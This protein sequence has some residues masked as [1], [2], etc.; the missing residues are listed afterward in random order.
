[1]QYTN[2][3]FVMAR[4]IT[5]ILSVVVGSISSATMVQ[6]DAVSGSEAN[7]YA[8]GRFLDGSGGTTANW[9]LTSTV[10][11]TDFSNDAVTGGES[12]LQ[13]VMLNE[14]LGSDDTNSVTF[15]MNMV[16]ASVEPM[17]TISQ[18]P[19]FDAPWT[20]N[21]G[22]NEAAQF[23]ISW[24]GGGFASLTDPDDQIASY[25]D[26]AQFG[27]GATMA[28]SDIRILNESDSWMI[29]LP[30]GVTAVNLD[31]ASQ[32]PVPNSDLTREWVTF[33]LQVNAV[34]EPAAGVMLSI[35]FVALLGFIRR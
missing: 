35:A 23:V 13:Y 33:D 14:V 25:D 30:A 17:L 1:M 34:P 12:G 2:N 20:W 26:G 24:D 29:T 11:G 22:N 18:S 7:A 28:F 32:S 31:W 4:L 19:Y 5:F 10:S 3:P 8:V 6:I 15:A 27:S 9:S 21:G 16:D